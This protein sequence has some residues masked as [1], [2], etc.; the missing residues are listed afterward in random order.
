MARE[1]ISKRVTLVLVVALVLTV[2]G[3]ATAGGTFTGDGA[4]TDAATAGDSA[5][6]DA[7]V[8][9]NATGSTAD[10]EGAANSPTTITSCT[11]I[12]SPGT[13]ALTDDL[14]G[15]GE[16]CLVVRSDGVTVDGRNHSVVQSDP[17]AA[18]VSVTGVNVTVRNVRVTGAVEYSS[19]EGSRSRTTASG[20]TLLLDAQRS[21]TENG[22]AVEKSVEVSDGDAS[23]GGGVA[24]QRSETPTAGTA[25]A[26][27]THDPDE[28]L[29]T[30]D[31][32]LPPI[33][34]FEQQSER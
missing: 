22:V 13:Y 26:G 9:E 31:G 16:A 34:G 19:G 3:V 21:V 12:R 27:V 4:P 20:G 15:D 25:D 33:C 1:N 2:A 23:A 7:A 6:V 17:D 5:R 28:G 11:V 29:L 32:S 10:S 30:E 14:S 8:G 18:A 24:S